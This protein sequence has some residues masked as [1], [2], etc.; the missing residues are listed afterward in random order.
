MT[1]PT[2]LDFEALSQD[3]PYDL[4]RAVWQAAEKLGDADTIANTPMLLGRSHA[5]LVPV[6][7]HARLRLL[8][9]ILSP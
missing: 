8:T 9:F 3:E 5:A 7:Q 2:P 1:R 4:L 6:G